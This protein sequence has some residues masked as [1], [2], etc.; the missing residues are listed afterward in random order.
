MIAFYRGRKDNN[1]EYQPKDNPEFIKMYKQLW[2]SYSGKRN[3]INKIV[4][5]ILGM[6]EHWETDLNLIADLPERVSALLY[7]IVNKGIAEAVKEV[8]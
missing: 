6:K 5:T 1:A 7:N 2:N 4:N 8:M 3:E